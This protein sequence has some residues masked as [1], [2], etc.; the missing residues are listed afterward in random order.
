MV[1]DSKA[2]DNGNLILSSEEN[3]DLLQKYPQAAEF[4]H[5][6]LGAKEYIQG[7]DR[8]CIWLYGVSQLSTQASCL[9]EKK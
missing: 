5:P 9:S 3:D 4:I 2:K 8:Y 7:L 6:F 1:Y